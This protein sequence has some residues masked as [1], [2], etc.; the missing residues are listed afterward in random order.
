M[1]KDQLKE[2]FN[3][4]FKNFEQEVRP[5]LWNS[6]ATKINVST[7]AGTVVTKSL[8]LFSKI[9]IA[10]AVAASLVVSGLVLM[11]KSAKKEIRPV[12]K[13]NEQSAQD[14]TRD[15]LSHTQSYGQK[16]TQSIDFCLSPKKQEELLGST[17]FSIDEAAPLDIPTEV[18]T[19]FVKPSNGK[20]EQKDGFQ[21][22][23]EN[24][25][26]KPKPEEIQ[27]VRD[28]NQITVGQV[29][30]ADYYL[31]E[32]PNVFTPNKDGINDVFLIDSKGLTDFSIVILDKN[33]RIV[34]QSENPDF[35]WDGVAM[36]GQECEMNQYIYFI[37]AKASSGKMITQHHVLN[38]Q[39]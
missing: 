18:L 16:P 11:N 33:N 22:N 12:L 30:P 2:L 36:D 34:F 5:E 38:L 21:L 1:E 15:T 39:R 13:K 28:E 6:L 27:S 4:T 20:S 19:N 24:K 37:T 26:T 29:E 31:G 8:S 7:T 23:T 35:T 25:E 32:L 17:I 9:V 3:E 14:S 10:T